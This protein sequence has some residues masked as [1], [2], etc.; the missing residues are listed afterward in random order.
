MEEER[1]GRKKICY[2]YRKDGVSI[3]SNITLSFRSNSRG[4]VLPLTASPSIR[5]SELIFLNPSETLH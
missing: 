2:K 5:A 4:A 3:H 1:E